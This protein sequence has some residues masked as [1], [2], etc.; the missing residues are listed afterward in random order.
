[1]LDIYVSLTAALVTA[2]G[3][4][5]Y[6]SKV[7][8]RQTPK[9]PLLFISS[10]VVGSILGLSALSVTATSPSWSSAVVV[11]LASLPIMMSVVFYKTFKES[12]SPL[13]DIQVQVGDTILPYAATRANGSAFTHEELKGQ[14]ILLKFFRGSWCPYCSQELKMFEEMKPIFDRYNVK[15][16]ALSN[17]DVAAAQKHQQRD[18][19]THLMLSDPD[20]KVI[21]QYGV[22]HHKALGG[23][24]ASSMT[25]FGLPFPT[26]MKYKPMAIPTSILIDENGIIQ[27]IDQA[28]DVRLRASEEKLQGALK[29][30]FAR[31]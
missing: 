8:K 21:K 11:L 14:R 9:M 12:K 2:A 15:I 25:L 1:M 6:F 13:G 20:L 16:V 26:K 10:L 23:D 19:L 17:D 30:S 18:H 3:A 7:K 4:L 24:G 22:E 28:E 31:A 27:W 29:A 5:S